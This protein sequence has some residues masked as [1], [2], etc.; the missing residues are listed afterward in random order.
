MFYCHRVQA[1]ELL[2]KTLKQE[3]EDTSCFFF[4]LRLGAELDVYIPRE[5]LACSRSY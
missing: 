4:I 5:A 1:A 2:R 3:S